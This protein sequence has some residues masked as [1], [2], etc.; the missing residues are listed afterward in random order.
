M[1][2]AEEIFKQAERK[3]SSASPKHSYC[4]VG[5][6]GFRGVRDL[7]LRSRTEQSVAN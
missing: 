3:L 5:L 7:A 2:S 6:M 1:F 4:F